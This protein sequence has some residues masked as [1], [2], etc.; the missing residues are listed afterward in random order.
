MEAFAAFGICAKCGQPVRAVAATEDD[1]VLFVGH[2]HG[3]EQGHC[4]E[5]FL[6]TEPTARAEF[7]RA[8]MPRVVR[9]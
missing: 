1:A 8:G 6:T 4:F 3:I 5:G 2:D 9:R 7:V